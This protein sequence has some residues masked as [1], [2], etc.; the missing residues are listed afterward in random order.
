MYSENQSRFG[1]LMSSR[2]KRAI[3]AVAILCFV[4]AIIG[5][6]VGVSQSKSGSTNNVAPVTGQIKD[7]VIVPTLSPTPLPTAAPTSTGAGG[8]PTT[9]DG[10][11]TP[12]PTSVQVTADPTSSP[13]M[14]S[15]V[16]QSMLDILKPYYPGESFQT[17]NTPNTPQNRALMWMARSPN[18][19][20]YSSSDKIQR[21]TLAAIYFSLGGEH[22]L[23]QTRWLTASD[24]CYWHG[25]VCTRGRVSDVSLG[26]N[27]VTG[28]FPFEFDF[29]KEFLTKISIP[30]NN[31]QVSNLIDLIKLVNLEYIDLDNN[32]VEGNIPDQIDL[33]SNLKTF[34]LSNNSLVGDIPE[35]FFNI[36][37]LETI[38]LSDNYFTG[39]PDM[40]GQLVNLKEFI[41]DRNDAARNVTSPRNFDPVRIPTTLGYLKKLTT[42][43][44]SEMKPPIQGRLPSEL[45]LM[46]ALKVMNLM[47][48]QIVGELPSELYNLRE[49]SVL[50]LGYN[51]LN[52]TLSSEMKNFL[53]MDM[54][55]INNNHFEQS[56]P[57]EVGNIRFL[58]QFIANSVSQHS[59]FC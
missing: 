5:I 16:V 25:I 2:K 59:V 52:G 24:E 27:N 43:S 33:L 42:L 6:S 8:E 35:R 18:F 19:R 55:K 58:N 47:K 1:G 3:L 56:I 40:I 17:L 14:L 26:A 22:W 9:S 7:V 10:V 34:K 48:N 36:T 21:Y 49:L 12:A 46:T 11:P 29:L 54:F 51:K 39:L 32:S 45:G 50:D 31:I 23:R 37:S 57:K 28:V 30:N 44:M 20:A 38:S 4:G 41:F 13:T 15:D 53:K